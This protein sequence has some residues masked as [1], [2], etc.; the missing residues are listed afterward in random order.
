MS[1]VNAGGANTSVLVD[2]AGHEAK[3]QSPNIKVIIKESNK[4]IFNIM[5]QENV[6]TTE[7]KITES[8]P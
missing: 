2:T 4:D 8:T 5:T 6:K 1:Q 3:D 7:L